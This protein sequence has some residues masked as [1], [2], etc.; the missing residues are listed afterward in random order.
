MTTEARQTQAKRVFPFDNSYA[1]LPAPF[2]LPQQPARVSAPRLIAV[3][4]PLAAELGLDLGDVPEDRL[5]ALFSGMEAAEGAEP[6]A[7]AYAG[8]QFGQFVPQLGDGRAILLGEVIGRDGKRCDIQLKGGGPTPFSRRGDGRAALGPV[9]REYIVSE[10]MA[11]LGVPTTRALA[12]VLTG[13][14]VYRETILPGAVFTR[15]AASHIRVGTFQYFAARGD[16]EALRRLADYVIARHYPDLAGAENPCLALLQGIVARQAALIAQWMAIGFIHGVMNTDNM[17]VSGETIDFGP[18]AFMDTYN[19]A[20]VFSSIDHSG[21]YAYRN[22][23]AVGQWNLARLAEA[24]LPILDSDIDAAVEL[25]NAA[26]IGFAPLYQAQ[27][28]MRMRAKIGLASEEDEDRALIEGFLDAMHRARADFTLSFRA[29]CDAAD[30]GGSEEAIRACFADPALFDLWASGW[31]QRLGRDP[32]TP[33]DRAAAM[34]RANPYVIPRNHRIEQVIASA[35]GN[36]D[37]SPFERLNAALA[38]PYE[39]QTDF[40]EYT[41]APGEDEEV[42]RTFCGT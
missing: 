29:L 21:R 24:M 41:L 2:Q 19:P 32:Q 6:L 38:Q 13:D 20:K 28:L 14:P 22:Q 8:H 5:A 25:A 17:T 35:A 12:A 26:V 34:R 39:T 27:W 4:R 23:P 31:R 18:C 1:R 15:V 11:A 33:K 42:L 30:E 7:M 16:H 40:A 10:A 37:F 3:N 36:G 9:L